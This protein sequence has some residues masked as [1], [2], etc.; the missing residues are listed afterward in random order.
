MPEKAAKI[1]KSCQEVP[2][3]WGKAAKKSG[4][5][6]KK[7][8]KKPLLVGEKV[9][10]RPLKAGFYFSAQINS[11]ITNNKYISQ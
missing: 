2:I 1:Q 9:S 11:T 10:R 5:A 6:A 7:A 8:A 4:K 3:G